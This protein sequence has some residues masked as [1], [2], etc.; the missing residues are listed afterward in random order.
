MS[1]TPG[2]PFDLVR[3]DVEGH[4]VL[5]VYGELDV[6]TSPRLHEAISLV[7]SEKPAVF[8][9]DMANVTFIDS[10]ALGT[11]VSAHRH[12][13]EGG[14]ELR[15]VAVSPTSARVF[16]VAGLSE[17]FQLFPDMDSAT[18]PAEDPDDA[19]A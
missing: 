19:T 4:P 2:A 15:L 12:M 7:V 5:V 17:R 1:D 18:S 3:M 11:L 10:S 14:G 13:A 9:I 6:L 8:L 16:E